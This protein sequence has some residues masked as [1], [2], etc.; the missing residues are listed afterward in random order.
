MKCPY[1]DSNK[2]KVNIEEEYRDINNKLKKGVC[3][4][5]KCTN[6]FPLKSFK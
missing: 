2:V 3:D 4:C 6:K 5:E 1:C